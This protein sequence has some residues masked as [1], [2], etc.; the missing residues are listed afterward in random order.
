AGAVLLQCAALAG[1]AAGHQQGA[2]GDDGEGGGEGS[3]AHEWSSLLSMKCIIGKGSVV[4]VVRVH[5]EALEELSAQMCQGRVSAVAGSRAR[6]R[7]DA[8]DARTATRRSRVVAQQH[9]AVRKIE[10]LID[11]MR[12]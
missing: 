8:A 2:R 11:V 5:A 6:H 3:T 10:G 1:G 7:R 12:H 9:D 4:A